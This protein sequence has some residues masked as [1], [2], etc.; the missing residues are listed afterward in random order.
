MCGYVYLQTI[1]YCN[2]IEIRIYYATNVPTCSCRNHLFHDILVC[3]WQW[4]K[5]TNSLACFVL[6]LSLDAPW[7]GGSTTS[8]LLLPRPLEQAQPG[9]HGFE[10]CGG[11]WALRCT[12]QYWAYMPWLYDIHWYSLAMPISPVNQQQVIDIQSLQEQE[13]APAK[14][15][16]LSDW[17]LFGLAN[18]LILC[19]QNH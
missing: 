5:R 10:S 4:G 3:R 19:V 13:I 17:S 8:R 12:E 2:L 1:E 11:M 16:E 18:C 7:H 14:W 9:W 6:S 15:I